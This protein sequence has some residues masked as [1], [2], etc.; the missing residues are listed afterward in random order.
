MLN[1]K[2]L[3]RT[4]FSSTFFILNNSQMAQNIINNAMSSCVLKRRHEDVCGSEGK[5]LW[6][7]PTRAPISTCPLLYND[8]LILFPW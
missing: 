5:P 1:S 2:Q 7:P 3:I 6:E 4:G 8:L